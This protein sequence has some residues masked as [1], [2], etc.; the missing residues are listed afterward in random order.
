[1][2]ALPNKRIY[3][4]FMLTTLSFLLWEDTAKKHVVG[5]TNL[6][7]HGGFHLEIGRSTILGFYQS[8]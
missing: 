2:Y 6:P 7:K 5:L 1:M 3:W 8:S 4:I